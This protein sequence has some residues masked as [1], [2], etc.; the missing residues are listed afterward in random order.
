MHR[1]GNSF[2]QLSAVKTSRQLRFATQFTF[3]ECNQAFGF[4][5]FGSVR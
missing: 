3:D 2:N 1:E 4:K 5:N